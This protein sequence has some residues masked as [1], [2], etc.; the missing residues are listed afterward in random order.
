MY[1]HQRSVDFSLHLRRTQYAPGNHAVRN[2]HLIM[3]VFQIGQPNLR[4]AG[5]TKEMRGIQLYL[6]PSACGN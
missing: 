6:S 5:N 3:S 1:A 4:I 2:L